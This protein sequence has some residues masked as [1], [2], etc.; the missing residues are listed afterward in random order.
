VLPSFPIPL[1]LVSL[2]PCPLSP[3][4]LSSKNN[5][6]LPTHPHPR[7]SWKSRHHCRLPCCDGALS[8]HWHACLRILGVDVE[9]GHVAIDVIVVIVVDNGVVIAIIIVCCCCLL[10]LLSLSPSKED[11]NDKAS[12]GSSRGSGGSTAWWPAAGRR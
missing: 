4:L 10:L 8:D 9:L 6:F 5:T 11:D 3:S 1:H 12:S 2:L 7:W